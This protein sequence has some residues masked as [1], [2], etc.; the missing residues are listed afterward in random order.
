M[1]IKAIVYTSY[2]GHTRE[3]AQ[4]LAGKTGLPAYELDEATKTLPKGTPVIYM[5]WLMAGKVKGLNKAQKHF[6]TE[7]VCGVGMARY[8]SQVE[9][10]RKSNN[11]PNDTQV[12]TL[13]GGY[14][15]EKLHGVYK[16]MMTVMEKTAGKGLAD[17]ADR[18][19][20]EDDMLDLLT[21]GGN[22]VCEEGITD[23]LQWLQER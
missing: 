13:Q 21:H 7:V 2:A 17:K 5:G 16:I 18:T 9:D 8:G 20:E 3:Y 19:P 4:L 10:V 1:G 14:D 22:R 6:A 12:F 11:I 23:I 15:R